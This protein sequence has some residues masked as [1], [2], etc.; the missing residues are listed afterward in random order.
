MSSEEPFDRSQKTALLITTPAGLESEARRELRALLPNV[1]TRPLLLKGNILVATTADEESATQT[2]SQAETIYVSRVV[3]VQRR[4][5]VSGAKH[6]K[7]AG[8]AA[9]IRRLKAGELFLVRCHRRGRH[10]WQSRDL[11]KSV[12]QSLEAAVGAIGEYEGSV[13]WIVS[14]QVFQDVAFIGVNRPARILVKE[15]KRHRKY[16]PG[17][18]PLNRAQWKIRE[19][20]AQSGIEVEPQAHVLDLGSA[21]GGWAA[22]LAEHAAEVVAVDPANLDAKVAALP[23]VRHLRCRAE[24]LLDRDDLISSF[25][26]LT[27][28]MNVDPRQ[29]AQMLCQLAPVLKE[30]ARAIMTIKYVSR[31]RRRHEQEA[32]ETLAEQYEEIRIGRLPHNA[33]ETTAVMRKRDLRPPS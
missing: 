27:C 22:V 30:G 26:L 20:L 31:A 33:R 1:D 24:E 25:D 13:D 23:N 21:P 3:P 18:R 28:D 16:A 17:Q 29:A 12:A 4:V 8:A 2:I 11:E 19:A 14:I 9:E 6:D 7:V 10:D 5:P 15:L 32:R